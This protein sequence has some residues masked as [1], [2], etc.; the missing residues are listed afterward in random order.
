MQYWNGESQNIFAY[1]VWN[2]MKN[3]FHKA[4]PFSSP[5]NNIKQYEQYA[6]V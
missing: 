2:F 4:L 3:Y 1:I 5:L 6:S